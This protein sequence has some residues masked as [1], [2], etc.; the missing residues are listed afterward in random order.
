MCVFLLLGYAA[1]ANPLARIYTADDP[2]F[3]WVDRLAMESGS[4][5]VSSA[6]PW[7]AYELYGYLMGI[8]R[9]RLSP[10]GQ[11]TWHALEQ[12][13]LYPYGTDKAE[14]LLADGGINL[15]LE[16][17]LQS[18]EGEVDER[19]WVYDWKQRAGIGS[20]YGEAVIGD[21]L[22]GILDIEAKKSRY[23]ND[24]DIY[25]GRINTNIELREY[26][27]ENRTPATAF[28][29]HSGAHHSFIFGRETLSWGRGYTGTLLIGDH[30]DF[31]DFL[32]FS[33]YQEG[34]KYS[35]VAMHFDTIRSS[36]K[37]AEFLNFA[38][39]IR[40]FTA[41]RLEFNITP[42]VRF[43]ATETA[44][45]LAPRLDLRMFSP[46][47]YLHNYWNRRGSAGDFFDE[48]KNA[49]QFELEVRLAPGVHAYSQLFLDQL[50]TQGEI[51]HLGGKDDM[52]PPAYGALA[53]ITYALPW[54]SG[55]ITGYLEGVYTSPFLYLPGG[56]GDD[57]N[58]AY[59]RANRIRSGS[60]LG[61]IGYRHGPD[62][63]IAGAQIGYEEYRRF[64][65]FG[66][67]LFG[68]QGEKG[69]YIHGKDQQMESG[70]DVFGLTSPTGIP[71]YLLIGGIGG[72][73]FIPGTHILLYGQM[74]AVT[75]WN[76]GHET[77]N[78]FFDIQ[79][80]LGASYSLSVL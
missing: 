66:S 10:Q 5:I 11:E 24:D 74:H 26:Y 31:H 76:S 44:L 57:Y 58:L 72:E 63:V 39:D 1:A 20:I 30:A 3:T 59:I 50:Q 77:G 80:V 52:P 73:V 49:F 37:R 9:G 6:G 19:D 29:A 67:I 12:R 42:A 55:Y 27:L 54:R 69:L 15:A 32:Q 79:G 2:L 36:G 13:L 22:Y 62:S 17:Y 68:L 28:A 43:A 21:Y 38:D 64:A 25:A 16:V 40:L 51:D 23:R 41:H 8:D 53:G 56:T 7:S 65:L 35:A 48:V 78:T 75:R 4:L 14:G 34:L 61:F 46:M 18:N 45:F 70:S 71:E 60:G 47:M 33:A